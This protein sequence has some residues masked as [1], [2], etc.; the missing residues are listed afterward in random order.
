[1]VEIGLARAQTTGQKKHI[2]SGWGGGASAERSWHELFIENAPCSDL[3][4]RNCSLIDKE[5]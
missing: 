2:K 4:M 1:M 3:T 5:K